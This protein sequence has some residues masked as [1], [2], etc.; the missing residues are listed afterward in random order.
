MKRVNQ[1]ISIALLLVLGLAIVPAESFHHHHEEA[2]L[3]KEGQ[4]HIEDKQ[5]ECELCS[6]VLP[7]LIQ[8]TEQKQS[9]LVGSLYTYLI[10][11]TPVGISTF[12][13]IPKYRGPPEIA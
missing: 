6:F 5:F 1:L 12:F 2:V 4:I 11:S 10:K 9:F 3:C 8:N 7:T 13:D